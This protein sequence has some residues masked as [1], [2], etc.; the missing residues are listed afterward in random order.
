L[1]ERYI[2]ITKTSEPKPKKSRIHENVGD[3]NVPVSVVAS[4]YINTRTSTKS[5]NKCTQIS[6]FVQSFLQVNDN[7]W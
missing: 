7:K 1:I 3:P 2:S 6:I 4:T 5:L